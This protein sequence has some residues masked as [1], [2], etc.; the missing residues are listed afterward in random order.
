MKQI[1]IRTIILLLFFVFVQ[2]DSYCTVF[3]LSHYVTQNYYQQECEIVY[4]AKIDWTVNEINND[5]FEIRRT[6]DPDWNSWTTISGQIN[7]CGWCAS[8]SYTYI[9]NGP[10]S[11]GVTYYY[12]LKAVGGWGQVKLM[13]LGQVSFPEPISK[14]WKN[15]TTAYIIESSTPS[16]PYNYNWHEVSNIIQGVHINLI[17]AE[18]VPIYVQQDNAIIN[19]TTRISKSEA[20]SFMVSVE[21]NVNNQG[22]T[23]IYQGSSKQDVVWDNST[24]IF[25]TLCDYNLKVRY[26][27]AASGTIYYREYDIHVIPASQKLYKDNYCNTIRVWEGNNLGNNIPV[28]FSEGFDAYDITTQEFYY[29]AAQDIFECLRNNA[30]TAYLLDYT[31][32]T[33]SIRNNAACFDAA[34]RYVSSINNN[35][36]VIAGGVSMGGLIARYGFAK[37]EHDD[38]PLPASK[39]VSVDGPQQ[40]A[41]I[42]KS[43]QDYKKENQEGDAF[44]EHALNNDAAKQLLNYNTYDTG[45]SIHNT[46]YLELNA[47]NGDGYP[48]LTENIGISFSNN[49]PNPYSGI[50][51]E[52]V[53]E[54]WYTSGTQVQEDFELEPEEKVA[55]SYLCEDLTAMSP[56]INACH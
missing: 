28:V 19:F 4:F 18:K 52:V 46:F 15:Q 13:D 49:N 16:N 54:D 1:K 45:G 35:Q 17:P 27:D 31:F 42:S 20:L 36:N 26:A 37:A 53:Y 56:I 30:H 6:T 21:V 29:F 39:F 8:Q 3:M 50:W 25:N 41:V 2:N 47:L 22:Y 34:V 24:S 44:A 12:R 48:H 40:G 14:D 7:G 5:Y 33:Q 38:N 51:L 55:G 23:S 43:L 10:F 32:G 9:D 11:T